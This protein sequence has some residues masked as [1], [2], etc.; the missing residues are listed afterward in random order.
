M[1]P[2]TRK[3]DRRGAVAVELGIIAVP[4]FILL[5]GTMEVGYDLFVQAAL[6]SAVETAARSVQVGAT[7]G[8]ASETSAQLAA[9]A[10]CPAIATVLS[11]DNIY[12]SVQPVTGGDYYNGSINEL[13]AQSTSG[14]LAASAPQGGDICTGT[15]YQFMQLNAW[16]I[17]PTFLGTL[18]PSFAIANPLGGSGLVHITAA[19]AGF[20][21]ENFGAG[22]ATGH[23]CGNGT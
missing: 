8:A 5:L 12:V 20:V 13:T 19:S 1:R 3:P 2:T 17:G 16:Y 7:V 18:I 23:A 22:Q 11:C 6:D 21:D 10:V 4:F 14:L 9:S 15:A